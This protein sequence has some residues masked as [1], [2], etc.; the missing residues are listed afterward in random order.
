MQIIHAMLVAE[1]RLY[2]DEIRTWLRLVDAKH[3]ISHGSAH[4][5]VKAL[6]FTNQ[7]IELIAAQRRAVNRSS[8]LATAE[9]QDIRRFYFIDETSKGKDDADMAIAVLAQAWITSQRC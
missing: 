4:A 2:L 3:G 8:F 9:Y 1:P 6:G 7:S 5:A